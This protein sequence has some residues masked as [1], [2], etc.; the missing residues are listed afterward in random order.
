MPAWVAC[1]G[2]LGRRGFALF[3]P[4]FLRPEVSLLRSGLWLHG[5]CNEDSAITRATRLTLTVDD[6]VAVIRKEAR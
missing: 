4:L 5:F 1:N 2:R 6:P 3:F